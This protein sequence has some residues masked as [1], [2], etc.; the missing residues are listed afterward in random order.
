MAQRASLEK[1]HYIR[2]RFGL[3]KRIAFVSGNFNVLHPGHLRLLKFASDNGDVLVVGVNADGTPGVTVPGQMRL[4]G[5][6]S[7]TMVD[8]ALLLDEPPHEFIARLRPEIVVKGKE[9][10]N[11]DNSEQAVVDSYGGRL[12]FSSGEVRFASINLLQRDYFET[13]FST[14]Q[15]PPE[16]PARHGFQIP[17]LKDVISSIAGIKVL[18]IGDLIID[19]YVDCEPLGM[20]REDPTL[21]VT[22]LN[23]KTFVGGAGIV[24][25]HA[26][27][28]GAEVQLLTVGGVDEDINF[29]RKELEGYGVESSILV[30]ETR[31]TTNKVR[32]RAHGKTLLRVNRL[33]QHSVD[34]ELISEMV[35]RIEVLLPTIDLLL[36][37]DFN[38]GCLPQALVDAVVNLAS[39]RGVMLAADSQ[40]S[41]QLADI[42]RFKSMTLITPT[43]HE[44]R[45]AMQDSESGLVILIERLRQAAQA[46]NV[47]VTLGAEGLLVHASEE[48][49]WQTDRLPAFNTAPKDVAGAGDCFFTCTALALRAGV[50]IWKST[51]L[52]SLA[53]AHQVSRVGNLPIEASDLIAEIEYPLD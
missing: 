53:A 17:G 23:Q 36:F 47:V 16:Y 30:D 21:V 42:S 14:I 52:G 3:G 32:Y 15:K 51:Y 41:S 12:L 11:H 18:V 24:A 19:T 27:G 43:E 37:S 40:A 35:R 8:H 26:R 33:R 45:L 50:D 5:L 25:A 29:A 38:Y 7:I 4:E 31:P 10:Q 6:R 39:P 20:S 48:G 46:E 49:S 44:A 28:L 1:L 22:P 13:N 34:A 9:Y 2:Q